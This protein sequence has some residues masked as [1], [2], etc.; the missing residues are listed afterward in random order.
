MVF[1]GYKKEI[2][3][4]ELLI[5]SIETNLIEYSVKFSIMKLTY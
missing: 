4:I 2:V 3:I 5:L 1:H